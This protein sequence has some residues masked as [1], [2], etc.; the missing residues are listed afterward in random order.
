MMSLDFYEP[1]PHLSF[2]NFFTI[3]FLRNLLRY[4]ILHIASPP[5]VCAVLV[6]ERT[7]ILYDFPT[8]CLYIIKWF[9]SLNNLK[10]D[11]YRIKINIDYL[12]RSI[13][14]GCF[15]IM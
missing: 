15:I 1:K 9:K 13:Y 5:N 2:G 14:T 10:K 8:K 12:Y 3:K 7:D 4:E 11:C 6:Y